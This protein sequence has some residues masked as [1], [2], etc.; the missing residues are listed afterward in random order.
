VPL[1]FKA[2]EDGVFT[3]TWSTAN[4]NFGYLHLVDNQT[5]V[6]YDMLTNDHYTFVASTTDA[7]ARFR[8][9]FSALGIG[10]EPATEQGEN[11]AFVSGDELVVNGTGEL[12]L[13]DLNGRVLATQ[14]V[15]GQQTHIAIPRVAVGMYMLRLSNATGTK[16]QK[17]VIR[18]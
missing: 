4:A 11:F 2:A 6:D 17:I 9:V 10:E 12:S 1:W 13:I 16:I 7:K 8:L 14:H 3:M 15:S 5:G 18:K